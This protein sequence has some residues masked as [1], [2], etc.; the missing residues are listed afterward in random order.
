M[1][2]KNIS[3][4][5]N[6]GSENLS[7]GGQ[8]EHLKCTSCGFESFSLGL[9]ADTDMIYQGVVGLTDINQRRL[10][11]TRLSYKEYVF[12]NDEVPA[13]LENRINRIF[14]TDSFK[15]LKNHP[16]PK[17]NELFNTVGYE[18]FESFVGN[19]GIIIAVEGIY[20][21]ETVSQ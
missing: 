14:N 6:L 4:T 11:I 12:Y 20:D 21:K 8:V 19:G 3:F 9:S 18:S 5:L 1:E 16:C 2:N 13:Q 15:Y 10:L 7:A 17:C